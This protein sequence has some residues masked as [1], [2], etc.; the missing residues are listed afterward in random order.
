MPPL[1][2]DRT[3]LDQLNAATDAA[4]T[5]SNQAALDQ[6]HAA[7]NAD[8][9]NAELTD[10]TATAKAKSDAATAALKAE[11][12]YLVS[13]FSGQPGTSTTG[14]TAVTATGAN[15]SGANFNGSNSA[16]ATPPLSN[17]AA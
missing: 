9:V 14:A 13:L 16:D 11:R 10:A 5:A 3:Q 17:Q 4:V 1:S 2:F 12:D 6:G 15:T 8:S 7:A